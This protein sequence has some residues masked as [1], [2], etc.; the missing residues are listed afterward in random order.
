VC[1]DRH[2]RLSS[3]A[4]TWPCVLGNAGVPRG[5]APPPALALPPPQL[6]PPSLRPPR[7][8]MRDV[9][10]QRQVT[11]PA[12]RGTASEGVRGLGERTIV[13]WVGEPVVA[14]GR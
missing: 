2:I 7:I 1:V 11:G 8:G 13:L 12:S 10:P 14:G 9:R 5:R 3:G 4:G 6:P